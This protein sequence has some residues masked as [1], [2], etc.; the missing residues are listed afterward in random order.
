MTDL[1]RL[2]ALLIDERDALLGEW[3]RRVRRLPSAKSLDTPTLND[4][5]PTLLGEIA[6][7]MSS[8]DE[9]PTQAGVESSPPA[10][11]LQR[12]EDGFDIE[13]VVAEYSMLR[14]C[15]LEMAEARDIP[16]RG[17]PV[18]ILNRVLDDAI[19]MAV[20]SFAE[21]QALEVQRRRSEH[22]AFIAHDLRT[23]L[24]AIT[25]ATR[26][27]EARLSASNPDPDA[28]KM[29]R[30][31]RRNTEQ[32]DGLVSGVLK[33]NAQLMAELG[34]KVERSVFDLWP[35]V[36]MIVLDL[37]LLAG[38]SNT[39]IVNEV[40]DG[41][42][43]RADA[44]LIRRVFQNLITNAIAY[45]PGGTV[46]IRA[47]APAPGAPVE[48]SVVDDGAGI[49]ASRLERIFDALET[50]PERD[51]TGLGLAIVKTF[52]EA[53]DGQVSVASVESQGTTFRFTLPCSSAPLPAAKPVMA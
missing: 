53:H 18:R 51:G 38:R 9:D 50:D 27:L 6:L 1:D 22:L 46:R 31:L 12:L 8:R 2:A 15:I 26:I 33:E 47:R 43:V 21:Y 35:V 25:L 17:S 41:L 36:E 5:I 24:G 13:E 30:I 37:A 16:M 28:L 48:C 44:T 3:R 11:G 19:G 32:L 10:H 42:S 4:H 23:P 7:A 52:I 45:T 29:V 34:V 49:P 14:G 40:P 20:K 39:R